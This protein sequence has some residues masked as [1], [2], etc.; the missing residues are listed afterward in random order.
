MRVKEAQ[1]GDRVLPGLVLVA[2][3]S[4]RHMT[5]VR[6]GGEYRVSLSDAPPVH[7]SRP[8]VDVLFYSVALNAGCNVAAALLTG[9]G[10]DGAEGLLAIRKAGGRTFAQDEASSVVFGMPR[11]AQEL[12][13]AEQMLPLE[14][15]PQALVAAA[16]FGRLGGACRRSVQS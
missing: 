13:A 3:G 11:A 10:R 14:K 7:Y 9:M 6:S 5:L 12:N 16:Q 15:M 2:P 8:S 4:Y 1:E